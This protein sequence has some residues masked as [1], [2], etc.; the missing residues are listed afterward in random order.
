[1]AGGI[2]GQIVGGAITGGIGPAIGAALPSITDTAKILVE[3]LVPDPAARAQAE[4]ELAEALAADRAAILAAVA[5]SDTAQN[6]INLAEAQGN[7]RYSSRWRPTIGWIG[8]VALGYQFLLAP[9]MGWLGGIV[10]VALGVSFPVPPML[11]NSELMPL[12][13]ALLGL[14]AS[15]TVERISGVSTA[16]PVGV[17]R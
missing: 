3:R 8:A 14:T 10:G 5:S 11:P 12:I 4:K 6:A 2:L 7:D 16:E 13:Y 17:N 15:R 9:L 1:M